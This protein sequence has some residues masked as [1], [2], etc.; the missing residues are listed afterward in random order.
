MLRQDV[1]EGRV[2]EVR[3]LTAEGIPKKRY[4]EVLLPS[5]IV[6]QPGDYLAVLPLNP[7]ISVQ[8]VMARYSIPWDSTMIIKSG[9]VSTTLPRDV[10]ISVRSLLQ[11]YIELG[12]P[13][14]KKVR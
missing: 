6:Y 13:A 2:E 1:R 7:E 12:Q 9:S 5:G 3:V 8:R 11:G 10:P 4:L 14:T